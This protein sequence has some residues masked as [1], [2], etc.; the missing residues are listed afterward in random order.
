[1]TAFWQNFDCILTEFWQHFDC[2]L[3]EFWLHFEWILTAFWLNF[4]W[5]LTQFWRNF[6]G[7]LTELWLQFD[8]ILTDFRLHFDYI[9]TEFWLP[10]S[11]IILN[12]F[13]IYP[14]TLKMF[15]LFRKTPRLYLECLKTWEFVEWGRGISEQNKLFL[16]RWLRP[17]TLGKLDAKL[18]CI[19]IQ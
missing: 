10:M 4:D 16:S 15:K 3:T 17:K 12:T 19:I 5:T 1:M 14:F 9:L 13:R 18:C 7:I 2:I 8:G 11:Y 6:D